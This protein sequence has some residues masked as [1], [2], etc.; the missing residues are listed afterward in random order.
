MEPE[1]TSEK[2][3]IR[4]LNAEIDQTVARIDALRTDINALIRELGN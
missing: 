3:D 2:I 1:D 4:A